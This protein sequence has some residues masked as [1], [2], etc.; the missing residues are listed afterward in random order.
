MASAEK[1]INMTA[2]TE[3]PMEVLGSRLKFDQRILIVST[4]LLVT[5]FI[6]LG[7]F[8]LNRQRKNHLSLPASHL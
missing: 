4:V 8:V 6:A 5:V 7:L 2:Q 1:I 3:P